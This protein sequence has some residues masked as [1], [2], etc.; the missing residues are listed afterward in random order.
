MCVFPKGERKKSRLFRGLLRDPEVVKKCKI[1]QLFNKSS[2][3][4]WNNKSR[5]KFLLTE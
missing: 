2:K 5:G 3:T 1:C 4:F